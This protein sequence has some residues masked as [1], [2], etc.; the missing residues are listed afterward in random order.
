RQEPKAPSL[1]KTPIG[2]GLWV[3]SAATPP[4]LREA[5][6]RAAGDPSTPEQLTTCPSCGAPL[7]W[8]ITP[9]E[10]IVECSSEAINC[11]YAACGRRSSD[12]PPRSVAL[13][14]RRVRSSTA[15]PISSLH[16]GSTRRILALPLPTPRDL[17]DCTSV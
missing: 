12:R 14:S 17:A 2:I 5:L 3:G 4:T 7:T 10:S 15:I 11:E 6:N 8:R 1:G 16:Q 13:Q 9:R